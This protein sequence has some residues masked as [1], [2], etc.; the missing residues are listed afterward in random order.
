[1]S[2]YCI[3]LLLLKYTLF[4]KCNNFEN[5]QEVIWFEIW[6]IEIDYCMLTLRFKHKILYIYVKD[7]D[8]FWG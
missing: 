4:T 1:M 6:I 8:V 3:V 2:L 7:F 5:P